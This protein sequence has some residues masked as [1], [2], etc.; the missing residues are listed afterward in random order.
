MVVEMRLEQL[1]E[2]ELFEVQRIGVKENEIRL[3][4][5]LTIEED[6]VQPK[7]NNDWR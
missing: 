2:E 1:R 3:A 7:K 6:F 5:L 4:E